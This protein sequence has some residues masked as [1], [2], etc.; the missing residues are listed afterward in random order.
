MNPHLVL[1]LIIPLATAMIL[2]VTGRRGNRAAVIGL[3]GFA[4]LFGAGVSLLI[5]VASSGIMA[6][7]PGNWSAPYG[8]TLV[9]DN[10]SA[11]MV[12]ITGL[13]GLMVFIYSL[14]GE[15]RGNDDGG[16][17]ALFHVLLMGVCGAFLAG[18]IFNLYV[19][20][21]VML[22]A[23]FVLLARGRSRLEMIA[24]VKYVVMNLVSSGIF[25]IGIGLLYAKV[26]S[27]NMA[28]IA[29]KLSESEADARLVLSTG[30]LFLVA[31]GIKAAVFPLYF[32]LPSSY[33][34]P[35]L[36]VSAIFSALLTKVGVYSLI[37]T[38]TLIFN[39]DQAF[40]SRLLLV[41][42]GLTMVMG[43]LGAIAQT[44]IRRILSFHIISQIGYMIM[45][46]ALMTPLGIAG[47]MLHMVHNIIVKTNLFLISGIIA[48]H[49]RGAYRIEQLG[50][51][52]RHKPLLALLFLVPAFSLA[53]FPPLSGFFTKYLLIQAGLE[54][55]SWL[56]SG[57]ALAVAMLTLVS[58][59][60]I[61]N[62]AFWKRAPETFEP[63]KTPVRLWLPAA[64][65]A[66][67]SVSIGLAAE[68]I[69]EFG[70]QTAGQL[71]EPEGYIE[72]VLGG[73]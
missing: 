12:A 47:A 6:T 1:P 49:G 62:H 3:I 30:M 61:W 20:F 50:G 15:M 22:I 53:G 23:S 64:T 26:G 68:P 31:F 65:L 44:D 38:F 57:I 46:L 4:G 28:D 36:A 59:T 40:S 5:R 54:T 9:A 72:A 43:G 45:G 60:K 10:L 24:S 17:Y 67:L 13:M 21:E 73:R 70:R 25:L 8:I 33:H 52:Y 66:S 27:L 32:W 18:D 69:F 19:W 7:G 29:V 71:L 51:L 63:M 41:I 39:Q 56:I 16:F 58:M 37:R 55:R 42:A 48:H 14:Y 11:L 34:A 35:P 2:F